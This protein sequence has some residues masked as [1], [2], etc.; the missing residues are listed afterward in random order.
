MP[1]IEGV[2]HRGIAAAGAPSAGTNAVQT[3]TIGA[4]A[5]GGDFK[6]KHEGFTTGAI[7]WSATNGTLLTNINAALDLLPSLG[8]SGAVATAGTLT[9]GIGT[10][11]IT[12]GANRA[13]QPVGL[14]SVAN[15]SLTGPA[16]LAIANTTPGVA[17]TG[18]GL[19][20]GTHYINLTNGVHYANT[21]TSLIPVW[22]V[23]GS[24]T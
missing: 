4:G 14:L 11:T 2:Q 7:A 17:A 20:I 15:N 6:L 22:T 8:T 23:I 10:V 5:T 1:I 16:T 3:L 19:P 24:Q 18:R 9:A 13:K 21:G 12:F